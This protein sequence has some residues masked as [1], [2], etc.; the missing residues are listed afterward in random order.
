ME[1]MSA[2]LISR[3]RDTHLEGTLGW[4][5]V[6]RMITCPR[7]GMPGVGGRRHRRATSV[8]IEAGVVPVLD[9]FVQIQAGHGR[10]HRRGSKS[11]EHTTAERGR[12]LSVYGGDGALDPGGI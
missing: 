2:F 11:L 8:S 4:L 3:D 6:R 7:T 5:S 12:A 10:G 9:A 1:M